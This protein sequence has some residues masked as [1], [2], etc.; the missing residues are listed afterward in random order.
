MAASCCDA[1]ACMVHAGQSTDP[2]KNKSCWRRE[3][4]DSF[5]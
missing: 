2:K 4:I 1:I 5:D 3:A